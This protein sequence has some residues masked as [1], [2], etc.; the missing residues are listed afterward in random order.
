M[1]QRHLCVVIEMVESD[2][3]CEEVLHQMLSIK[4]ALNAAGSLMSDGR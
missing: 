2:K 1:A 3:P 4:E